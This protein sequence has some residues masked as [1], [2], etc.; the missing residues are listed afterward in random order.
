M[1]EI[2]AVCTSLEKGEKK[3]DVGKGLLLKG[4]GLENDAHAG[5]AHRQVSLLAEESI[6]IMTAKGL[7]VK[8]GDFAE[9]L[10]TRGIELVKLPLGT[11]L[12]VGKN[13]VLRI[14]QIGKECYTRCAI[15][16]QAGDCIM[17]RE[18]VFAEVLLDG[19]VSNGDTISVKPAYNFGIITASDKGSQGERVD[20]SGPAI[21]EILL[22]FGDVADQVIVPDERAVLSKTMLTMAAKGIDAIFTT[23]GTGLGPRDVT[24]E[25]TL[26]VIDRLVPGIPEA[27][28]RETARVTVKAMLSRGIAG[29]AGNTLIINLPGSPKAVAE[30]LEVITPILDHALETLSGQGGDCART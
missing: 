24:P 17:P 15:F 9:N 6:A 26:D 29:I 14:T 20:L 7:D 13:A 28:R 1:A 12:K 27:I 18:G 5:F 25:A 19:E 3:T 2:V 11:R 22:P 23:G 10:T 30:C 4:Q 21:A 16:Q 8:A